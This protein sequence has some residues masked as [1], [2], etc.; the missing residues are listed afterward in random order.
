[1]AIIKNNTKLKSLYTKRYNYSIN[2]INNVN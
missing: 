2:L 1:M